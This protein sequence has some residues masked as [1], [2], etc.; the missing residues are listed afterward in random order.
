MLLVQKDEVN[1]Q[2]RE[3]GG[4]LHIRD[5]SLVVLT[6]ALGHDTE[7]TGVGYCY[8]LEVAVFSCKGEVSILHS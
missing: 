7:K 8:T 4:R 3:K 6:L 2:M 1:Q 5:H